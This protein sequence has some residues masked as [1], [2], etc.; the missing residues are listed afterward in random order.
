M[1]ERPKR[2]TGVQSERYRRNIALREVGEAGQLKLLSSRVL[3]IGAGGLGSP[4]LLYLAA[5]GVGE[6]GIADGDLVE[7]SNLQ[8]QIIHGDEDLGREKTISARQ[9][10]A[11]IR[12]DIRLNCYS[13]RIT[14]S[15]AS[16]I[17]THYDFVIEATDN[18]E[19]K[20]LINDTCV[21]LG[22]PFSH[23]GISAMYGQTMTVVPGKGPCF[24]CVFEEEPL[25]GT[26]MTTEEVGVLGTVAGVMG[27]IQATEALK[28]LLQCGDLLVSRLLTW[29]ASSMT[30]RE[31]RLPPEKRCAVCRAG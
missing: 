8:R 6:I 22:K 28:H 23:A 25:P 14:A 11:R 3:V 19:S 7:L 12:S 26:V 4:A 30:F 17:I 15:N 5:S 10:L 24:R 31:I 9:S 1:V 20:F 27:T 18:F 16:E 2:L 13:T 29:D 21:R